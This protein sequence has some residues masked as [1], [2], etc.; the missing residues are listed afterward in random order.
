MILEK[1]LTLSSF[2]FTNIFI[3]SQ[4]K[5]LSNKCPHQQRSEFEINIC[6]RATIGG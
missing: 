1:T 5:R 4:T 2:A 3:Y 6:S